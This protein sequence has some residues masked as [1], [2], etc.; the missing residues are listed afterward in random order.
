V[1]R[2]C[3]LYPDICFTTEEKAR[4]S[5]SQGLFMTHME[6]F[7][8]EVYKVCRP[9]SVLTVEPTSILTRGDTGD[10][11]SLLRETLNKKVDGHSRLL[12]LEFRE[13]YKIPAPVFIQVVPP[14][15]CVITPA[16]WHPP[17]NRVPVYQSVIQHK[18]YSVAY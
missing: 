10:P 6:K 2:I 4:K 18:A 9:I 8:S 1:P 12:K 17:K 11:Q 15:P 16:R 13:K 3:E 5:L 14:R 7:T